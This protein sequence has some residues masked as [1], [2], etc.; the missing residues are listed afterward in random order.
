[1]LFRSI[2]Y[3][4][5]PWLWLSAGAGSQ[6]PFLTADQKWV[7]FPFWDFVSPYNNFSAFHLD[8]TFVL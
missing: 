5:V 4:P 7:R 2:T 6:Q 1:M 3:I 8:A